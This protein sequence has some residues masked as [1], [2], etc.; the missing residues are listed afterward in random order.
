MDVSWKRCL[1]RRQFLCNAAYLHFF[2]KYAEKFLNNL[3]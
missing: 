2:V 3:N 1:K